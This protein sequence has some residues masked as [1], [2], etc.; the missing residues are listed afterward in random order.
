MNRKDYREAFSGL[1]FSKDFQEQTVELLIRQTGQSHEKEHEAMHTR[2]FGKAAVLIAAAAA[3]LAVSVSAAVLL[4]SPK[5]VAERIEDP[6]LAAALEGE[7]AV[8]LNE[9]VESGGYRIT[10]AG[11]VSGEDLSAYEQVLNGEVVKDRT[12]VVA[13]VARADGISLEEQPDELTF[14]PL[15][16]GYPV[17]Q[18]N[19]WTMG[20]GLSSF[21]QDGVA[22]YI[23]DTRN[24][25]MFADHRVYLAVYEG[26]IPTADT[27]DAAPD[28]TISFTDGAE[29]SKALFTLPLNPD[30]ADPKAV[31]RFLENYEAAFARS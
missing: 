16:G 10:L 18:V 13:T 6:V 20:G 12:Y 30:S 7:D 2:R 24:L 21:V 9:A 28:G 19:I 14:T 22:Y 31:E 27:F 8:E 25:E 17:Q 26:G 1:S 29:G 4:L 5:E 11:M 23:M 3:L 15:V